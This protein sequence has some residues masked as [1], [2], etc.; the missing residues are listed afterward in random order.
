MLMIEP[1]TKNGE[2]LRSPPLRI[3]VVRVLDHRQAADARADAHADAFLVAAVAVEPGVGDRLH[4]GDQPVMDERVVAARF[5][6][7]Q[8]LARRRSP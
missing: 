2:I 6:A 3:G 8:V 1:G 7:G 4:R 5:L